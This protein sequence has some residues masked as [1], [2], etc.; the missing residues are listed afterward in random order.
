MLEV[1]NLSVRYGKH[2][3]LDDVSLSV[4]PGEIAVMLGANGAG[5]TTLLKAMAGLVKFLP[6]GSISLDGQS[7]TGTKPHLIVEAGLSLVPEGRL[8]FSDLTVRDNLKLGAFPNRAREN[9]EER[10]D[11]ILTLF[12]RLGERMNQIARTMSGGEQQMVAI[13]RAL[14]SRP[15][16]L[17][18]DEPSLGLSPLLTA[19]LF[20]AL[21]KI[22]ETG[23]GILLVEQN[24]N[25]TLKIAQ[26]CY[27]LE[28]GK[29][30]GKGTAAE[31]Q[32]DDAIQRAYLGL[33]AIAEDAEAS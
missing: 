32:A 31:F 14:M 3:A 26:I 18:L 16:M 19:E 29:I 6:G 2:Q 30:I 21:P 25:H 15:S 1:S 33:D 11:L 5:K 20:K 27:L 9:V 23:L 4:K 13:G 28:N 24:T 10:L 17:L 7:L 8:L 22:A 12:P